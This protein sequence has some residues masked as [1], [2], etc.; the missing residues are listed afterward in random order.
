MIFDTYADELNYQS[1]I[2]YNLS[3]KKSYL[4]AKFKLDNYLNQKK[5]KYDLHSRWNK[6]GNLINF[7][8]SHDGSRQTYV[9]NIENYV[10]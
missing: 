5:L 4:L 6:K 8:S 7:D 9:L 10:D 1:L 3:K 2:L